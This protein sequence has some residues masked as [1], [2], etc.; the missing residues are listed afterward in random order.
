MDS[1]DDVVERMLEGPTI[2]I[3]DKPT[4]TEKTNHQKHESNVDT[5]TCIGI[6]KGCI[7][8]Q[9][10]KAP[11]VVMELEAD[12]GDTAI[13]F[14]NVRVT[15]AKNL[16]VP[17]NSDFA[18]LYR[19]A[20]G[21]NPVARFSRVSTLLRHFVGIEFQCVTIRDTDKKGSE[22]CKVT[23]IT[24]S[25]PHVSDAWTATGAELKRPPKQKQES[26]QNAVEN[27]QEFGND[28]SIF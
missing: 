16:A 6:R 26:P 17:R 27:Q 14:F 5:F 25:V 9:C 3:P 1:L 28:L 12:D 11:V 10:G 8:T 22:F 13:K 18:R 23:R 21:E 20:T 2:K 15:K 24:P 4:P 19:L 7:A